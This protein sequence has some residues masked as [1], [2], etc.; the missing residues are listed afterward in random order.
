MVKPGFEKPIDPWTY[1]KTIQFLE[2]LLKL[3]HPF[4]PFITEEIYHLISERSDKDCVIVSQWPVGGNVNESVINQMDIALE[5][6]TGIRNFR[7]QKGMS[8]K[9]VLELYTGATTHLNDGVGEVVKKL[10]NISHIHTNKVKPEPS[11]SIL[12]K[13]FEFFIPI[14]VEG[15]DKKAEIERLTKELEYNKG[16]LKSVQAKLANERFISNAKPEV[17]ENE[18]K[19]QADAEA[20]INS[21]TELLSQL[22]K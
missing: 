5:L 2:N 20:K 7:S 22:E 10:A 14:S 15:I 4:M 18:R 1:Q 8:P 6:I 17:I 12:I 13:S 3:L 19:K 16:F 11:F 9:Q 21:I